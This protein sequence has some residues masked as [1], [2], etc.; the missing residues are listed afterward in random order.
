MKPA[1]HLSA[2]SKKLASVP[3]LPYKEGLFNSSPKPK[4]KHGAKSIHNKIEPMV[5]RSPPTG[6]S[7]IQYALPI[8]LSKTRELLAENE[9]L[10][11]ITEQLKMIISTMEES[12]GVLDEYGEKVAVKHGKEDLSLSVGDDM[13]SFLLWCTEFTAQL[14]EAIKEECKV[15]ESLFKWFQQQ[16]NQMEEISKD[17]AVLETDLPS[18]DKSNLSIAQIVNVIQK[19]EEL[20]NR[21]KDHKTSLQFKYMYLSVSGVIKSHSNEESTNVSETEPES[22]TSVTYQWN[23]LMKM[24]ENQATMLEKA[25]NDQDL[26]E[27]KYKQMKTDFDLL[28]M[29]KSQLENEIQLL[30]DAEREASTLKMEKKSLQE[31]LRWALQEAMRSKNQLDHVLQQELEYFKSEERLKT[32]LDRNSNKVK[33]TGENLGRTPLHESESRTT[34]P[35]HSGGQRTYEHDQVSKWPI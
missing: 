20:K 18:A 24:F 17:Q 23:M 19:F 9:M 16:V 31:Q 26:T 13:K 14:E 15:L 33:V 6:E 25:L 22:T 35:S 21:L 8:P 3:E 29:E 5:L 12:Y 2:F 32:K 7:I 34:L 28:Y 11:R 10:R 30:K 27:A 4:E 1:R